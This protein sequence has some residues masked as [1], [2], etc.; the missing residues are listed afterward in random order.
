[1]I[2]SLVLIEGRDVDR[3]TLR[4]LSLQ[5]AKQL[6]IGSAPG[7]GTILHIAATSSAD[8]GKALLD[9]AQVAN[10]KSIVTLMVR[11]A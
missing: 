6:V 3:E 10:V 9:F 1:M 7:I 5:N 8:L 2:E 11:N 4:G